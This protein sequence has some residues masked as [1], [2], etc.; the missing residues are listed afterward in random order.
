MNPFEQDRKRKL[1][2]SLGLRILNT[3]GMVA[4]YEDT[5]HCAI[6]KLRMLH[7]FSWFWLL[8]LVLAAVVMHGVFEVAKE[9]KR[10]PEDM[11]WW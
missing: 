9:V 11:V 2:R 10:L 3:L 8:T 5:Y 1:S 7:P 6:Q 4:W